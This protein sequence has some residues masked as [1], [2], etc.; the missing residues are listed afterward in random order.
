LTISFP[1]PQ[2]LSGLP[3]HHIYQTFL[4][5][6]CV[7]PNKKQNRKCNNKKAERKLKQKNN[8]TKTS[9]QK[10]QTRKNKL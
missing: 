10:A 1:L 3:C 5:E 9:K 8:K 6:L 2:L 4:L 7:C